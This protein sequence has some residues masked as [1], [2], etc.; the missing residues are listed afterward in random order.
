MIH[1]SPTVF[2]SIMSIIFNSSNTF[3][4]TLDGHP[5]KERM[6]KRFEENKLGV[7]VWKATTPEGV[8]DRI[9]DYLPPVRKAC[10]QS[11]VNIWK[12]MVEHNLEY[13][14]IL[15]DDAMFHS[16]WKKHIS[17]LD[18][19]IKQDKEWDMILLNASEPSY[20]LYSWNIA[21]DN[22][23]LAGYILSIRGAKKMLNDWKDCFYM[24]D[25]MTCCLQNYGHS[26]TYFPW[27]IIQEGKETTIE[28]N[29]ESDH[30]KVIRYLM[31]VGHTIAEYN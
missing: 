26:Y 22:C 18:T 31:E 8:T 13:A 2:D 3:C 1:L 29:L 25:W 10:T 14:F 12:Y 7:T 21:K 15:E 28:S 20:P 23:L 24:C 5:R 9:I 16:D 11:H 6:K 27:L 30:A 17:E 4:I 19:V